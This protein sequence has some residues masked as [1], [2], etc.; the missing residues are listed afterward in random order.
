M[1]FSSIPFVTSVRP[2]QSSTE[3][4]GS[5]LMGETK[6]FNKVFVPSSVYVQFVGDAPRITSA[7]VGDK[8]NGHAF[9]QWTFGDS[10]LFHGMMLPKTIHVD[11]YDASYTLDC[12]LISASSGLADL[13]RF[14]PESYLSVGDSI[15]ET[16][17]SGGDLAFQYLQGKSIEE[18]YQDE[19]VRQHLRQENTNNDNKHAPVRSGLYLMGAA[20]FG[21]LAWVIRRSYGKRL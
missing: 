4:Q 12:T 21:V 10:L 17:R 19:L 18:M 8:K 16:H 13:S 9:K 5:V 7:F 1:G 6:D 3:Y 14:K 15:Q 11:E 20:I 2:T